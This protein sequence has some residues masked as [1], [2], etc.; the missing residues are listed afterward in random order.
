MSKK[1]NYIQ[2]KIN[3][4]LELRL[5][6]K[7]NSNLIYLTLNDKKNNNLIIILKNQFNKILEMYSK[8]I[9]CGKIDNITFR[10]YN[11]DNKYSI[12]QE[13]YFIVLNK[14]EIELIIEYF[15]LFK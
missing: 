4:N 8:N 1:K 12:S 15:E 14:N 3:E 13:F 6:Y 2:Y 5:Y 9:K 10:Y 11:N 7:Y